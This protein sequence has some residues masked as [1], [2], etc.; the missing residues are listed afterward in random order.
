MDNAYA[1]Y[2][3]ETRKADDRA[4]FMKVRDVFRAALNPEVFATIAD[5]MREATQKKLTGSIEGAVTVLQKQNSLSD[6]ERGSILQHL[7]QGSD[8]SLYGLSQ[9]VTRTAEDVDSYDRATEL[10]QLG[11]N[12]LILPNNAWKQIAEAKP[13][14]AIPTKR[15]RKAKAA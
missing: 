3:D 12:L 11:G 14:D 2:A 9:A 7:I 1:L 10:E 8:L 5:Q 6:S 4:F 13:E 15:G